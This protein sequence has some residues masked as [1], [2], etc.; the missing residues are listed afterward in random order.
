VSGRRPK[1]ARRKTRRRTGGI[2]ASEVF[3]ASFL[4]HLDGEDAESFAGFGE[5]LFRSVLEGAPSLP[6]GQKSGESTPHR[7]LRAVA[8]DLLMTEKQLMEVTREREDCELDPS[9]T[10]LSKVAGRYA[11]RVARI[12]EELE[13]TLERA[14]GKES[15]NG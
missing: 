9:D 4:E 12:R 10:A 15:L 3:R 14:C 5:A 13:T 11:K 6:L 2:P 7:E 8:V 1:G